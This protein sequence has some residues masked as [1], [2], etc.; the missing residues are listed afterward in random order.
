MGRGAR[1]RIEVEEMQLN[2]EERSFGV[3]GMGGMRGRREGVR[4]PG[5][6]SGLGR[7]REKRAGRGP[8][9]LALGLLFAVISVVGSAQAQEEGHFDVLLFD[10]GAGN[11]RAGAIDVDDLIPE[12]G[13]VAI[14]G[15]LFG[16][17]SLATPTFQ[18]EDP[19]FFSVSDTNAGLLGG[20]NTNLPGNAQV[21][22]D[23]LVEPTL[24]ISL[25]FWDDAAGSFGATPAG[26][27]LTLTKG[28]SFFGTLAGTTEI[29]GVAIGTTSATGFLDDHPDYDLGAATPGVYLAFGQANVEGLEGPSNPFWLIFGTLDVCEE[30]ASCSAIQEAFNEGI[31]EQIESAIDYVNTALVP[32]P[33]TALLMSLGL[34]GLSHSARRARQREIQAA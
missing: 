23:F 22:V 30:T 9:L 8:T 26:E 33:S 3:C 32:E 31:E 20:L 16:D 12:L 18:G 11:L 25:A 17:T 1:A 7:T 13:N 14:E 15:E 6:E 4:V 34:M 24:N 10:D 2:N 27:G 19:G 29:L 5:S 28:A 21:T